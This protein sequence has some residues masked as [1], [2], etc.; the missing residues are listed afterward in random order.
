[1]TSPG[2]ARGSEAAHH[3][4][5]LTGPSLFL[6]DRAKLRHLD[7][8]LPVRHPIAPHDGRENDLSLGQS[9]G[10]FLRRHF[11]VIVVGVT[12]EP[13]GLLRVR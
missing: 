2:R 4:G 3:R 9:R 8:G 1:M 10:D 12:D 13:N 5:T 6:N 11:T 7:D